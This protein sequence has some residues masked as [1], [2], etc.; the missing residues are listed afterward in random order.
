MRQRIDLNGQAWRL[1]RAPD[2]ADPQRATWQEVAGVIEWL[3][4]SVPGNV[5]ADLQRAGRLPDLTYGRQFEA[6]RWVDEH[7]WW[8][9][10]DLPPATPPGRR[11]HLVLRGVDYVSDVFV[12]GRH[13]GRHEGMF[14]PQ[15]YE[16]TELLAGSQAA[17][18]ANR[19]AVRITGSAWLPHGRSSAWQKVLNRFEARVTAMP[20]DYPDRRD[21]FKCQMGFG[22]DFAPPVRTMGIWDA[23][24]AVVS[25]QV[26][27]QG[28]ATRVHLA[29]EEASLAVE[30]K[31]DAAVG[32]EGRL[33]CRLAP[34]TFEAPAITVEQGVRLLPGANHLRAELSVADARLWWPWDQG[35]PDLYRLDVE[36]LDDE[37]ILDGV[38]QRV[39]LRHIE[40][41]G[42][43]AAAGAGWTL[44]VNGRPVYARGA[45]WVPASILPGTAGRETYEALLSLAHQANM[46]MLRVWGG[47]LREKQAFYDLCDRLGI[48]VWQEF[49]VACSF[50]TSLPRSADYLALAE[51]EGRAIVRDLRGHPSLAL[52]CG[53]NEF[54]PERNGPL[55]EA[56][57]RAV[58][59]EDGNRP[60]LPA[61]PAGG[62]SHY[63]QVWHNYQPAAAYRRDGAAFASEFGMQAPPGVEALRRFLPPE[64]VW[65]PGEDWAIHGANLDKLW[66]YA[67]P[68]LGQGE[69]DVEAFVAASQRAQAEGLQIAVEH[70]R[71][72]R[73]RG[74]GGA[75][76]WQ[77]NEPWPAISW[78]LVAHDGRPKQA[79]EAVRRAF[80]PLLVSIEYPLRAYRAGDE[81]EAAVW[82][83]NDGPTALPGGRMEVMLWDDR[84]RQ[85]ETWRQTADVTAG[86]AEVVGRLRWRLPAGADWR[87][88]GRLLWGGEILGAN[89]YRLGR[90]EKVRPTLRRRAWNLM[91]DWILPE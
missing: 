46:N 91:R 47:G 38:A 7:Q 73:A 3:P 6:G 60:F 82:V 40:W 77:L 45:N 39:G 48:L 42:D 27:I 75:L 62:D 37:D 35:R 66:H 83:I 87:L 34:E 44:R 78:A 16:I 10:R 51:A 22:W 55:V 90:Y 32:L 12:N 49:P 89:E 76:I 70:Y 33:R 8:F 23:V 41:L 61:S 13:L 29:G 20:P 18:P 57:A 67:R 5:R 9:I 56:L 4:A 43:Q 28:V 71:R 72:A 54:D 14:S 1:G 50:V 21:T 25:R 74:C 80:Q 88:T 17:D 85:A 30:V 65:P 52:W 69:P 59:A 15:V 81:V 2:D 19:L 24:Y 63:W 31:L 11:V 68:Y 36:V 79:Y 64:A 84:G 58:A 53:G 86:S 26:F